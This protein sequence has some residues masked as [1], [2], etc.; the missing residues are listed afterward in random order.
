MMIMTI[1]WS[2]ATRL[3]EFSR[4]V[5]LDLR[6]RLFC[7]EEDRGQRTEELRILVFLSTSIEP[8]QVGGL[9]LT[10]TII[11]NQFFCSFLSVY[12]E[13]S[14][15]KC[16]VQ[17]LLR[18]MYSTFGFLSDPGVRFMGPECL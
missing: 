15:Q 7:D 14:R 5:S 4:S 11:N 17:T 3:L 16:H 18:Q 8:P 9:C 10:L 1:W 6:T 2:K 13:V 12:W